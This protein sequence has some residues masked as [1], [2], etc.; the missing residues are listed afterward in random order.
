MDAHHPTLLQTPGTCQQPGH[1]VTAHMQNLPLP[2]V[3]AADPRQLKVRE[4]LQLAIQG[5]ARNL[6][7]DDIGRIAP[8]YAADFVAWD[9][10]GGALQ[11]AGLPDQQAAALVRR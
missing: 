8:G 10:T 9:L 4:A 3:P 6:G 2:A 1:T 5:G 11:C 7:R